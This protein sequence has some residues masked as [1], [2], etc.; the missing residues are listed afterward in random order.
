MRKQSY[1]ISYQGAKCCL[2]PGCEPRPDRWWYTGDER[3]WTLSERT[4]PP[5]CSRRAFSHTSLRS[6]ASVK[7]RGVYKDN[8][9]NKVLPR[10]TC[11]AFAEPS[12]SVGQ[13]LLDWAIPW[14]I[15]LQKH[16]LER[17]DEERE[18]LEAGLTVTEG[19][20]F[21]FFQSTFFS[22]V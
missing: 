2:S 7:Q 1:D 11:P 13:K 18:L 10:C 9:F 6:K 21:V 17:E 19:I 22:P 20:K 14:R 4:S 3:V 15:E 5:L 16:P 8:R 12:I